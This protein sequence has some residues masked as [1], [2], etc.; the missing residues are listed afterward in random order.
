MAQSQLTKV[1]EGRVEMLTVEAR[2]QNVF[3]RQNPKES[4]WPKIGLPMQGRH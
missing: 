2:L 1:S 4:S 3:S